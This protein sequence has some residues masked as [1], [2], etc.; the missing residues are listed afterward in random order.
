[1][2][3]AR[4][5]RAFNLFGMNCC[6]FYTP[7]G[8]GEI[9]CP[10]GQQSQAGQDKTERHSSSKAL[11]PAVLMLMCWSEDH[12]L[13]M[14]LERIKITIAVLAGCCQAEIAQYQ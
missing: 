1:M 8:A 7:A 5:F 10:S 11:G 2:M 13:S 4:L 12:V 14:D 3:A 9:F 6:V